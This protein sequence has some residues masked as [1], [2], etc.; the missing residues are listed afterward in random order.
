MNCPYRLGCLREVF[1]YV[2]DRGYLVPVLVGA[3]MGVGGLEIIV[4]SF[5]YRELLS[6]GLVAMAIWPVF[7]PLWKTDKVRIYFI[8]YIKYAMG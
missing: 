8:V 3:A 7:T 2:L 5:F 1:H 6:V 4:A